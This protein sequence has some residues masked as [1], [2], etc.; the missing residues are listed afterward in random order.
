MILEPLL[1]GA[2]RSTA[3]FGIMLSTLSGLKGNKPITICLKRIWLLQNY[4]YPS[5][6]LRSSI[7]S[8]TD[9]LRAMQCVLSSS[10]LHF[11]TVTVRTPEVFE[12]GRFVHSVVNSCWMND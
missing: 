12:V 6:R 9:E 10:R 2:V 7:F 5:S 3:G 4:D 1:E 11:K 8:A